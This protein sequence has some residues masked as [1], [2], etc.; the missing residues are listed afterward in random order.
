[1]LPAPS[2]LVLDQCVLASLLQLFG[3]TTTCWAVW[4]S[5][6]HALAL[7][8]GSLLSSMLM[9]AVSDILGHRNLYVSR[10]DEFLTVLFFFRHLVSQDRL[11]HHV[12]LAEGWSIPF[13]E[14][15]L[16]VLCAMLLVSF[17]LS[18]CKNAVLLMTGC[19]PL[20]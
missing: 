10:A 4:P 20:D 2:L 15:L 5:K 16:K 12:Q 6:V 11:Q 18:K 19:N 7:D 3:F 13:Q 1:M 9:S 14:V 8:F 17:C